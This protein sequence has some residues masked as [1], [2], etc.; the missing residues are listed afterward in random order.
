MAQ[1][2]L[3]LLVILLPQFAKCCDDGHALPRIRL[4]PD[5]FG[6]LCLAQPAHNRVSPRVC[7]EAMVTPD[8]VKP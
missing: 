5:N 4:S 8:L 7:S 2:G 3:E 1:V 6:E